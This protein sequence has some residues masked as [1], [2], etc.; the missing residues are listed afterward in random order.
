MDFTAIIVLVV[1]LLAGFAIG[2]LRGRQSLA[3]A[4]A[5]SAFDSLMQEKTTLETRLSSASELKQ[6]LET[7]I[8]KARQELMENRERAIIAESNAQALA[9]RLKEQ[10][11]QMKLEFKNSATGLLEE[12]GTKFNTQSEKQIGDLLTPLRER[13]GE[14]Q[15][16]VGESFSMQGKEQHALKGEITKIILQADSLTK[17]LK[18]DVKAQGN[19]G[20]VMLERILE[21]SGLQKGIGYVIQGT[22]MGLTGAEG[23]R[24]RPDVIV[25]LPENKHI[26][27]DSKVSLVAYDRYCAATDELTRDVQLKE[28]IKSIR[29]HANGL[30]SKNY[31]D[32]K[33]LETPDLV[34]MFM[35]FEGAYSLAIQ[36]DQELHPYA[37]D[38][39]VAIVC[40]STLFITLRT[41]ASLWRI[42]KQN[43]YA[44]EI[45]K[46]GGAL[47]D[48]FVGFIEDM[49]SI[50]TKMNGLQ[51][52][53]DSAMNKLS[54]GK[55]HL[56]WQ[57]EQ[58]KKLGAKV[59]KPMPKG[60]N[61]EDESDGEELPA[62]S[63]A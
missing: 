45:A 40:P 2:S 58:L 21:A 5:R 18:G 27:V 44:E 60:I 24:L 9:T 29:T 57:T 13:M 52:D 28:F 47:Y 12:I 51:K 50:G 34:L 32:I 1:G 10:A 63:D 15:K 53:Y 35:P 14:F 41:I 19:W 59:T 23:N 30:A 31:Q 4:V 54:E 8:E 39:R 38:K 3:S 49:Q 6:E 62:L 61:T 42:E 33:G 55:G 20:E 22:D 17:A 11:E 25:N 36:E 26:I 16:M 7:K 43:K 46:R 37:W 48:K 56:V